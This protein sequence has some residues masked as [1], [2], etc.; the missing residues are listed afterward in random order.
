MKKAFGWVLMIVCGFLAFVHFLC[1]PVFLTA[2]NMNLG[3]RIF[4]VLD[5]LFF[6]VVFGYLAYWGNCLRTGKNWKNKKGTN[7]K[8]TMDPPPEQSADNPRNTWTR[9]VPASDYLDD[10]TFI[11]IMRHIAVPDSVWQ[12]YD[13]LLDAQS[14]GWDTMKDW[15][16]YMAS[17]DLE[18]ITEVETG[19]MGTEKQNVTQSYTAHGGK[20][21][22][23]PELDVEQGMLSIA[24]ISRILQLPVKIVWINQTRILR[25]FTIKEDDLQM[26]KYVETMARRSFGT[27]NAMKLGKPAPSKETP[28]PEKAPSQPAP[29]KKT[30]SL[31]LGTFAFTDADRQ[32][33]AALPT[34]G[35][36]EK[37][38]NAQAQMALLDALDA[39][40]D[41]AIV[42]LKTD[43]F[44][45]VPEEMPEEKKTNR[46]HVTVATVILTVNTTLAVTNPDFLKRK[47]ENAD[48]SQLLNAWTVLNYYS[49]VIKPDYS[50]NIRHFR[51]YIHNALL[52]RY[53]GAGG[54]YLVPVKLDGT[55]IHVKSAALLEWLKAN[56][57]SRQYELY[58][59]MALTE[60]EPVI[61]LYED[62]VKTREYRLQ[63]ENDEDFTG[64]YFR[65]GVRIGMQGDPSVPAAQ[66][67]GFISDTPEERT[68][69][70]RDVGYRMEGHFLNCGGENAK[71]RREMNRGQD[72]PMKALK[73]VGYTIPSNIRLIGICPDCGKSF[74]FHG[75]CVY[76]GQQDAAYS[77]DGLDCCTITDPNISR[78][79]WKYE[80][81]GKTFRF[82]NS[83]CCPHCGT[84]YI[85]YRR[86]PKNKVFGVCGCVHLGR[87]MYSAKI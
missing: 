76:M 65:I 50:E 58:G 61:T 71:K 60:K 79:E 87:R 33:L 44:W 13:V 22:E 72:L 81:D 75:Y 7:P 23:T 80:E 29:E 5:G 40:M 84:P 48:F 25:L 83:F 26:R 6:G 68:M 67:D 36:P 42:R 18:Q 16:D 73:Y 47:V 52:T 63:T 21:K 31:N 9:D 24:G 3:Q 10:V 45:N 69:N 34:K 15:A 82:Y 32:R 74:T 49:N 17:A 37:L 4:S 78:D 1:I 51:D 39:V 86:F 41:T 54:K 66:I 46:F 20:C 11:K 64:K 57:L 2:E 43:E 59:V 53:S 27:E 30:Q 38:D 85:D 19:T 35:L 56:P 70:T 14:Y 55:G 28:A 12:Q 77:D 8:P 62:G